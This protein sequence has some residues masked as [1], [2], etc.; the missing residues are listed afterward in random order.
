MPI[1][2]YKCND[3]KAEFEALLPISEKDKKITCIACGSQNTQKTT[4]SFKSQ[5]KGGKISGFGCGGGCSSCSGCG[6]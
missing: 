1:Y 3:C 4:A 5:V 6:L 2:V